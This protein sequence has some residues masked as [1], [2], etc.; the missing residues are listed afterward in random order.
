MDE[1]VKMKISGV[2]HAKK[3]NEIYFCL[4]LSENE[5]RIIEQELKDLCGKNDLSLVYYRKLKDGHIPMY[6]ELKISGK[7]NR[8]RNY[9]EEIINYIVINPHIISISE[10]EL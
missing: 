3:T 9:L 7:I 8:I 6:R 1:D 2:E 5:H 4:K 10:C